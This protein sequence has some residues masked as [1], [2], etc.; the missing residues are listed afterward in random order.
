M[1]TCVIVFARE[2]A[3]GRVKQRLAADIGEA[4]ALVVY[5]ALLDHALAAAR[6]TGLDVTLCL[7]GRGRSDWEPPPWST[8]AHQ[9]GAGLG[10][11]MRA[12]LVD[13]FDAGY[14]GAVLFGTDIPAC[15]PAQLLAAAR[16]LHR[17]PVVLGPAAD[18]GYYLV[19]QRAPG[20]DIFSDVPWSSPRTMEVTRA[21]LTRSGAD[22]AEIEA[23][24]DV[25]TVADLESAIGDPGLPEP[26]RMRLRAAMEGERG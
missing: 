10:G 23:L 5:R 22:H 4:R 1:R 19:A 21:Q 24:A 25:D 12:A 20:V 8:L 13:R 7:A 9:S 6:A 11:R 16:L 14:E 17:R 2:P 15:G 3:L 18:G 26:L